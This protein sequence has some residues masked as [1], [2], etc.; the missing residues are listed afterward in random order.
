MLLALLAVALLMWLA[1][2]V[3]EP[4]VSTRS[5]QTTGTRG[6]WRYTEAIGVPTERLELPLQLLG[7]RPDALLVLAMPCQVALSVDEEDALR[8][9][10]GQ[11]GT[12]LVALSGRKP[13]VCEASVLDLL[14]VQ[15]TSALLDGLLPPFWYQP[16]REWVA[17]GITWTPVQDQAPLVARPG[18]QRVSALA[19]AQATHADPEGRAR[20]LEA[21]RHGGTVLVVDNISVLGNSRFGDNLAWW[22]QVLDQHA[23]GGVIFDDWRHGFSAPDAPEQRRT[24]WALLALIAHGIG[25]FGLALYSLSRPWGPPRAPEPA[26]PRGALQE[27]RDLARWHVRGRHAKA[28]GERLAALSRVDAQRRGRSETV[29]AAT[30]DAGLIEQARQLVQARRTRWQ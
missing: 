9:F 17:D 13:G 8:D 5:Q 3:H 27:L 11:G 18:H 21:R 20:I 1:T 23:A 24:P 30:D 7:E 29:E 4:G 25:L 16:W 19:D 2:G 12:V 10:L 28:A 22:H 6:A 14:D 15:T 26:H